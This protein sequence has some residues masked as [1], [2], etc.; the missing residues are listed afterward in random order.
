MIS[1]LGVDL[2]R[3]LPMRTVAV[4]FSSFS[5]TFFS[6]AGNSPDA[7]PARRR[8]TLSDLLTVRRVFVVDGVSAFSAPPSLPGQLATLTAPSFSGA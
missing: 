6:R 3:S 1:T 2:R 7:P 8:N 5:P 4:R